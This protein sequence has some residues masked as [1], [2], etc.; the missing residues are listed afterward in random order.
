ME[1]FSAIESARRD[2]EA[3]CRLLETPTVVQMEACA[4]TLSAAV[5]H[6]RR[7]PRNLQPEAHREARLLAQAVKRAKHLLE[8]ANEYYLSWSRILYGMSSSYTRQGMHEPL[9]ILPRFCQEA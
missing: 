4:A 7:L 6:L 1:Q 3:A 9:R 5:G 8:H 2:V